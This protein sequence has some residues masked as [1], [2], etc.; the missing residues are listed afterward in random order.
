MSSR[1]HVIPPTTGYCLLNLGVG[2]VL[3]AS[4]A[5]ALAAT[6]VRVPALEIIV[7]VVAAV[8]MACAV[9]GLVSPR[10]RGR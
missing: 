3:I 1:F 2:A 7:I 6:D 8:L 5:Y 9:I 10:M 4:S